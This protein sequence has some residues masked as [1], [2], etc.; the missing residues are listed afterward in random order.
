MADAMATEPLALP[1]R[2]L[3]V[4]CG[5]AGAGKS[6]FADGVVPANR[7]AA[8]AVV[9]SDACR[10]LLCDD[11]ASVGRSEWPI[12][13]PNTFDLFVTIVGMHMSI[14]RPTLADGVILPMELRPRRLDLARRHHY[15]SVLVVFDVS[16]ETCL[17]QN[18]GRARQMPAEQLTP[19]AVV[20][21]PE[22]VVDGHRLA[23]G[24]HDADLR[25]RSYHP[26]ESGLSLATS[27]ALLAS[28]RP[29]D[30]RPRRA[31]LTGRG[32][33][34]LRRGQTGE[35]GDRACVSGR[36]TRARPP[37]CC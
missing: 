28:A 1:R 29:A 22:Q 18:A 25:R 37:G 12:L 21:Q 4:L 35:D 30:R 6:S 20:G 15:R 31:H 32:R 19:H 7:L 14:G 17:S 8:T 10:L 34:V 13:Q 36:A 5:P 24:G 27:P 33:V 3:I 11:T 9:S 16:L 23:F 2:S 26:T